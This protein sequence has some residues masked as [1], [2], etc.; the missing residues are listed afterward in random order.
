[1]IH[2]PLLQVPHHAS[3]QYTLLHLA[4][5]A[6]TFHA[7]ALNSACNSLL[8]SCDCPHM[9]VVDILSRMSICERA[10]IDEC[11]LDL[12]EEAHKRLATCHGQPLLPV[13]PDRV[14]ICGQVQFLFT[15]RAQ[16]LLYALVMHVMH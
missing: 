2:P 10:S 5:V 12:T 8:H 4:H 9:Q 16:A 1:M 6:S 7:A 14:H 11:Y 15:M 3:N 13:N